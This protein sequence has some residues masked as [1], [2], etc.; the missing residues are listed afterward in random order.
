MTAEQVTQPQWAV[1]CDKCYRR[2]PTRSGQKEAKRIAV[3]AGWYL[4]PSAP[5]K[6]LCP[7][8]CAEMSTS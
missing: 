5:V 4:S 8:C 3:M 1:F 7:D 6:D 2:G